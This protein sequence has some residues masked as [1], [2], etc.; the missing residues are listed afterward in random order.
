MFKSTQ[1]LTSNG[2]QR[3]NGKYCYS[4]IPSRFVF[5]GLSFFGVVLAYA[6]KVVLSVAIVSMVGQIHHN[7]NS[8]NETD[9]CPL[10]ESSTTNSSSNEKQGEFYDWDDHK[11]A[12]ILGGFFYGYVVTQLPAGVLSERFGAKWIFGGSMLSA[13]ILSLLGPI[14]ARSSSTLFLITRIGQGLAEGVVF[15]CM[16][17]MISRWMPKME[18]SRGSTIIFTG[19]QIGTVVTLPLAGQLCDST[20]LGGWPSIFYVLGGVGCVWFVLWAFFVHEDPDSH[21]YISQQEYDYITSDQEKTSGVCLF[22]KI[23][24]KCFDENHKSF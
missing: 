12:L 17:A 13:A 9:V 7:S 22:D 1:T 21:P 2:S 3:G 5:V 6:Y 18:R 15:P 4:Y 16:N 10:E 20:F 23:F 8:T 24:I 19:A 14:A 11:Q